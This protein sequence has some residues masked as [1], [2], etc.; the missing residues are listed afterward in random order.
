MSAAGFA[1]PDQESSA[2]N[3]NGND[4]YQLHSSGGAYIDAFG[5]AGVSSIWYENSFAQRI[6]SILNGGPSY[7]VE[8]WTFTGLSVNSP[9][10]GSPGTPGSH[11]SDP[12]VSVVDHFHPQTPELIQ[13]YPNPFNAGTVIS[14]HLLDSS[15]ATVD[16][17][18]IQGKFVASLVNAEYAVGSHQIHWK[19]INAS[20]GELPS[21]IYLVRLVTSSSNQVHRLSIL[22]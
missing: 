1:A 11:I 5:L 12:W 20:G 6:P 14:F 18:D 19:G 17:F 22:R 15:H 7:A 2:I 9:E 16:V 10:N 4:V 21:G 13:V 8:E 3:G